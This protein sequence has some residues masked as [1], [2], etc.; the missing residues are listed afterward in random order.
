MKSFIKRIDDIFQNDPK[1]SEKINQISQSAPFIDLFPELHQLK[2]T[3]Q[4]PSHHPEGS[5]WNHTLLVI[6]VGASLFEPTKRDILPDFKKTNRSQFL[7]AC[8]FHD[9]GKSVTTEIIN[10]KVTSYGHDSIGSQIAHNRLS[11]VTSDKAL[12]HY[13]T[14][15]T[16]QHMRMHRM[17]ELKDSKIQQLMI[18]PHAPLRDLLA[19][20]IADTMGRKGD[21]T[22]QLAKLQLNEKIERIQELSQGSFGQIIPY[23]D[24][25]SI[26]EQLEN[27]PFTTHQHNQY[28]KPFI[29]GLVKNLY[30][31]QLQGR[32][33]N[34]VY[35]SLVRQ[36]YQRN[37]SF[38]QD[39]FQKTWGDIKKQLT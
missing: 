9:I 11:A 27:L 28:Q 18:D 39:D 13:V 21:T 6:D 22:K 24:G 15:M 25:L 37:C 19:L 30:T 1:P 8:L 3:E 32:T 23:F 14:Q 2:N 38:S 20:N 4:E 16:K 33:Y 12:V 35:R 29:D 34:E 36:L 7:W 26:I 10:G 31:Q 5:A 17:I